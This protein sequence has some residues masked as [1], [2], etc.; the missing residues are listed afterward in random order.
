MI[1][2][3]PR[4]TLFPYTTLF[5]SL[6]QAVTTP[7][8]MEGDGR[9]DADGL[10]HRFEFRV[11]KQANGRVEGSLQFRQR[12]RRGHEAQHEDEDDDDRGHH[13]NRFVATAITFVAFSDDPAITPDRKPKVS[14]DTVVFSGTGRWNGAPGHTFEVQ[15]TDAGEPG[16]GRDTFSLTI[17]SPSGAVVATAAGASSTRKIQSLRP[18]RSAPLD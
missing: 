8:R 13:R 10:L 6:F 5:R 14:V 12:A 17:R 11:E 7:G 18:R 4:S 3:P 9:I 16:R 2:R 15:A 1:R